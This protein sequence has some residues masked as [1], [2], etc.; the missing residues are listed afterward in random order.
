MSKVRQ[1]AFQ[2]GRKVG[3]AHMS[4]PDCGYEKDLT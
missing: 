2:K 4:K 1:H 3:K